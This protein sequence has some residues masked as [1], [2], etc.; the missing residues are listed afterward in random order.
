M[1][2]LF[3]QF[4]NL[5]VEILMIIF[6]NLTNVELLYSLFGVNQRLNQIIENST[7]TS[8]L[9]L[10]KSSTFVSIEHLFDQIIDRFCLEILPKIHYKIKRLN[11]ESS[12]MKRIL[13]ISFPNL[14]EL[15]I[16]IVENKAILS[17]FTGKFGFTN[18]FKS[19]ILSLTISF[20]DDMLHM[21]ALLFTNILTNFTNLK[22]LNFA[23]TSYCNQELSFY[24][25]PPT[26]FSSALQELHVKVACM[27]D[28]LYLLDGRFN[29]LQ[30]LDIHVTMSFSYQHPPINKTVFLK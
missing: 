3:I 28:C 19:Q 6:Q 7:F 18:V 15:G 14:N 5:P 22:Y 12:S 23:P 30:K 16:Y 2:D 11:L 17:L 29:Q 1:K 27:D 8:E 4:N 25:S 20:H 10:S 21:N 24:L 26:I 9:T 13:S